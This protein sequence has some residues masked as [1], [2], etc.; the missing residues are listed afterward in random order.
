M[1]VAEAVN[2]EDLRLGARR[3]LPRLL[4]DWI[5]GGAG[6]EQALAESVAQFAAARLMPRYL[7]DISKRSLAKNLF[8]REY[9][10]PFGVAPMGNAGLFRPGA[11]IAMARAAAAAN[12]PFIL[13]GATI[14]TIEEAD[15]AAPGHVAVGPPLPVQPL[16]HQSLQRVGHLTDASC[17]RPGG[18]LRGDDSTAITVPGTGLGGPTWSFLS[19]AILLQNVEG[20]TV[21]AGKAGRLVS[22]LVGQSV[23]PSWTARGGSLLRSDRIRPFLG[24]IDMLDL[25]ELN[26]ETA[27]LLPGR[28][29]LGKLQFSFSKT[30]NVTQHIA[31][32]SAHNTSTATNVVSLGSAAQS[33]ADQAISIHQ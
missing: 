10:V 18:G 2:I 13:S 17:H 33:E 7:V 11:D 12:A 4:F 27:E 15:A 29:A 5:D 26:A 20:K 32:V 1:N 30:V 3:H 28:E 22:N 24:G 25:N 6:D 31:N 8:G 14:A 19:V 16:P 23:R 21:A 9:G